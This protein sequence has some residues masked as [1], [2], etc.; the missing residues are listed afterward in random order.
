MKIF[1]RVIS[2]FLV[3]M[4]SLSSG[5][6]ALA[7]S[8]NINTPAGS[9]Q[10][11]T[12]T[13]LYGQ[14]R[15]ETAKAI[16]VSY[17]QGKVQNVILS[18]GNGFADALSASVLA[19]Q[20]DAPIL[21]VDTSVNG[22][23][24]AYD[25]ITQ[26]LDPTGT[27][28]IIGG[29]GIIGKEFETKLNTLGF[30]NIVRIAGYD[31]YETS[32][33]L[34]QSLNNTS[35]STVVISSGESYPDA[36]SIASFAANKGWPILLTPKASLPQEMRDF[37]LEKKP[38]KVYITGGTGVI[39]NNVKSEISGILP[40]AIVERLAGQDRFDTNAMIAQTFKQNPSTIYLATGFGFA[41]ALA[42]SALA[43]KNGDP[44]LF[45]DPSTPTLPKS[46]ANYM[47]ELFASKVSP[48][49]ITF[50]GDSVVSDEVVKSSS[51]LISGTVK[52]DSIYSIEDITTTVT[53]NQD[54]SLPTT[55][56][57]KLY[58][59]DT[60]DVPVKWN[61]STVD[62]SKAGTSVFEG[63]IDGYSKTVRLNI[64]SKLGHPEE[65]RAEMVYEAKKNAVSSYFQNWSS[66][67]T[68]Y[69]QKNNDKT[70]S[71]IEASN[72]VTVETYD[73][74]Y[75]LIAKKSIEYELPKF[76]GFY[77]GENYNYIAFGQGN[78][79]ENDNKEVIR[80]VRY[81][82]SFKRVDSVSIKG[83]ESFTVNPF[84]AGSGRMAEYG[85]K[86]VFHTSRLRYKTED[87]L[88][89]QSQLTIIVNTATMTVTNNLGP[90]QSNHVSHSF[91]Q[92]VLFDDNVQVLIDHG[93]AYPRSIVLHKENAGYYSTADL[94]NIAGKIGDNVTGVSVGGFESSSA[95]YIVAM[96]SIDHSLLGDYK[97][98][99]IFALTPE[100][101]Q[102]D[103]ILCTLPKN[104]IQ[105][106]AAK[107]ITLAK[108]VGSDKVASIP[109]LVKISDEKLMVMWQEFDNKNVRGDLKY[110]LVDK[111]GDTISEIQTI[112]NFTLSQCKPI[113][114]KDK[115]VWYV[116]DNRIRIF[117]SIPF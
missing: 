37:L 97:G 103:I 11:I 86:L 2:I 95:N 28:F 33:K 60:I 56:Q 64:Q 104:I 21:L 4:I 88:H 43:A 72:V 80:I 31:R 17:N 81:D 92:Y 101:R 9:Q 62:T 57:A 63:V 67:I 53:L 84:E 70:I 114:V 76:G 96:N 87:G 13:R 23:K 90:F 116:N 36:L 26:Q 110:V 50:G 98:P 94:L 66:T 48:N 35:I 54:Y 5:N 46:V 19:H 89:H 47:G 20:K 75:N 3:L 1:K 59:S 115:I 99:G 58:N 79:E 108:Y 24:D 49:L 6:I 78:F 100:Q 52:E 83:G 102:R 12:T 111:N 51:D 40:Q 22:S 77:S 113:I 15:L 32:Y 91:D 68:S 27:V 74:Q 38:S 55:V 39:S 93:D 71:V 8:S 85:N 107:Q 69:L 106:T 16:A 61:P 45:I 30:N 117:Y 105:T 44:I 65:F 25:Y 34:A 18:T 109:Q 42:G 73:E 7:A 41:D 29:T 82:K 112:N 14:T 10:S